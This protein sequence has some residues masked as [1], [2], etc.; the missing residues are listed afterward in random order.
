MTFLPLETLRKLPKV[1][2]HRHLEGCVRPETFLE[3]I[4]EHR[5]P[6]AIPDLAAARRLIQMTDGDAR[7]FQVFLAKFEPLRGFYPSREA[8]ERVACEAV[9]DAARDTVRYLELRFSPV[10]FARGRG[11]DPIETAQWIVEAARA[12]AR[13]HGMRVAFIATLGRH[14]SREVNAPTLQAALEMA[15]DGFVGLDLAGDEVNF[16]ARDF[17]DFLEK[18]R[19]HGLGL[20][21]HAGELGGPENV[22]E[23]IQELGADRIGHGVRASEDP[24]L[25]ELAREHG[26]AFEICLTSNLHT[27]AVRHLSTHPLTHLIEAGLRVTLNTDD[28]QISGITLT[29]EYELAHRVLG[30]S[31]EV[32]RSLVLNA[33]EAAF[34]TQEDREALRAAIEK[35]MDPVFAP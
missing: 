13:R 9:E 3:I 29:G 1:E 2:L 23:A 15:G 30:L 20:T 35:E 34:L 17:A 16:P 19:D 31:P 18:A 12:E 27:G 21:L 26:V 32:L 11:F 5:L 28:P 22:R 24:D 33:L 10:H 4:R 6:L 25:L 8:I 14:F 7:N